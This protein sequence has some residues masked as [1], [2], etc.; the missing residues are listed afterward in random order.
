MAEWNKYKTISLILNLL[1]TMPI[2]YF[3]LYTLLKNAGVDRLVWF[4]YWI[5]VPVGIVSIIIAKI[6]ESD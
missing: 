2:W 1:I 3:L 6:A 4:L 5:Y